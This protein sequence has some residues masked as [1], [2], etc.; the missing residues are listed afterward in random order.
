LRLGF[1]ELALRV[2]DAHPEVGVV[3]GDRHDFGLRSEFVDVP[4][5]NLDDILPFNFIDACAVLRKEV[6]SACG[7]Y[8]PTLPAWED[9]ELWIAAAERGWQ[10]QHLPGEAFDYRVRPNSMVSAMADEALRR[11][12]YTYIISKHRDLYWRR[13]PELLL[14]AQRSAGDLFRLSREHERVHNELGA[15]IEAQEAELESAGAGRANLEREIGILR[16]EREF[17]YGELCAW[18]ERVAFM[19]STRAWRI[20]RWIIS[21]K[22][23]LRQRASASD[24][25]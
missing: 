2:L 17:A 1:V 8:D 16:A 10:F 14:A 11:R 22:R 13:L 4:P 23:A 5:F 15:V 3:Y 7:G 12:L 6:W 25:D 24:S 20:R 19:E 21:L 9:W 18:Q